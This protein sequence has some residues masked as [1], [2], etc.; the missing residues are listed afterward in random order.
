MLVGREGE[1]LGPLESV[2]EVC[3]DLKFHHDALA[4]GMTTAFLEV[5]DRFDPAE[6]Q[7]SFD[8]TLNR[9]P[10]LD[11]LTKMKYWQLYWDFYPDMTVLGRA[12]LPQQFGEEFLHAYEKLLAD[13][14]RLERKDSEAA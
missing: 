14:K 11:A 9:K 8:R 5:M 2:R 3:R 1:Y 13:Y 10:L 12:G 6:L 4:E 7:D